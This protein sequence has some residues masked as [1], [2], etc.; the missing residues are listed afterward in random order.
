MSLP[1]KRLFV[2]G[3][4]GLYGGA[5][6]ELHHQILAWRRMGVEVHLIPSN[7]GWRREP[8]L[9]EMLDLGV[10]I[11]EANDWSVVDS[12]DPV[13]GFCNGEFLKALPHIHQVVY[14]ALHQVI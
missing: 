10:T 3:F 7:A 2:N 14:L 12:G 11:H 9:Q 5:G 4:P 1:I 13:M 6:T 8:L